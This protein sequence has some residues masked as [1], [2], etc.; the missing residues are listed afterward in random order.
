MSKIV[1]SD[2]MVR[3]FF[4]PS[5]FPEERYDI[6][7]AEIKRNKQDN[8]DLYEEMIVLKLVEKNIPPAWYKQEQL[9]SLGFAEPK[10]VNDL[11]VR[12]R[13]YFLEV[14]KR[15]RKIKATWKAII[16]ELPAIAEG[17]R[18]TVDAVDFFKEGAR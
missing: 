16:S 8:A 4:L 10:F 1:H 9:E 5:W 2:A 12:N 6:V 3:K 11:P 15:R 13:L 7:W 18:S 14:T 17:T